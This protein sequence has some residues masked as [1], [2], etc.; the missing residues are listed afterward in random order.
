MSV[1][2]HDLL[3]GLSELSDQE[4]HQH[5]LAGLADVDAGRTIP[6]EDFEK[7]AQTLFDQPDGLR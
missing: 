5:T 1:S 2:D 4:K 6:H 7:W 3:V